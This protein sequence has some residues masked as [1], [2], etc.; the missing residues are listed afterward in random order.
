[1]FCFVKAPILPRKFNQ[2]IFF[3]LS[4]NSG[5]LS[6]YEPTFGYQ[7]LAFLLQTTEDFPYDSIRIRICELHQ[8]RLVVL[9]LSFSPTASRSSRSNACST[10]KHSIMES[11]Q[12]KLIAELCFSHFAISS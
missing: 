8:L 11:F 5:L 1:M 9:L 3:S 10:T 7:S 4:F 12:I 6:I 2:R